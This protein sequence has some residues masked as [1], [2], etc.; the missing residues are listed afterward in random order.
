M[1]TYTFQCQ[2][3]GRVF[4]RRCSFHEDLSAMRCPQG[5]ER[6]IRIFRPPA[7]VFKGK[8]FYITDNRHSPS[9]H[10]AVSK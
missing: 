9:Q 5:H 10:T 3:C 8:G 7:L 4:N 1:P 2:E 6:T